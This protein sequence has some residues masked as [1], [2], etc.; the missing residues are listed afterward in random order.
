[1]QIRDLR[2]YSKGTNRRLIVGLIVIVLLVGGAL[3]YALLGE[4]AAFLGVI[5]IAF[6]LV[7]LLMIWGALFVMGK[8]VDKHR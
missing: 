5:C 4:G 7:I 3:I 8:I 6:G 1:M 2:E